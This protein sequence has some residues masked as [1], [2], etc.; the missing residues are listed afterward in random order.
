MVENKPIFAKGA[1]NAG[2]ELEIATIKD[3]EAMRA[4]IST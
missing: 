1:V 2:I 4:G 3:L